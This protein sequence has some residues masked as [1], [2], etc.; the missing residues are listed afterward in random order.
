MSKSSD[1]SSDS[2]EKGQGC[3]LSAAF[4]ALIFII[5]VKWLRP[6]AIPFDF[7]QFWKLD[8]TISD[9]LSTAWPVFAWGIIINLIL[10]AVERNDPEV[11]R[12][13]EVI[14][15]AGCAMSLLAGIFE[16][17]SFRWLIFYSEIVGYKIID[18]LLLGFLNI[19]IV[20]WLYMHITGPIANFFTLGKLESL[21]FNGLGWAV[22]AAIISSNGKFREGHAY[23]GL[24]GTI[25][26]WFIGMFM[27]LLMFKFGLFAAIIVHFLYDMFIFIVAYLGAATQRALGWT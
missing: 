24:L 25:N 6:T 2:K 8:G 9:V 3:Y 7:W 26:A 27:F 19:H 1:S 10:V 5:I 13:A 15:G 17:I 4:G 18:F 14:L 20:Q 12:N 11:N 21:L 16:E 22:G 23:Q